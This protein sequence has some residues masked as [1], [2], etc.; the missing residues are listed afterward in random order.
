MSAE[1][2]RADHFKRIGEKLIMVVHRRYVQELKPGD[3]VQAWNDDRVF[4]V[5]EIEP[6]GRSNYVGLVV[7]PAA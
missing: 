3:L 2:I 1:R 5:K 7:E 6:N 4:R